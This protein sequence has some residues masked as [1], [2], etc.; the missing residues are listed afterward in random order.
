MHSLSP[1]PW[2]RTWQK[3]PAGPPWVGGH[4][5]EGW[6]EPRY[7][8]VPMQWQ[9]MGGEPTCTGET[10]GRRDG[11]SRI[12][13]TSAALHECKRGTSGSGMSQ[14]TPSSLRSAAVGVETGL[15]W[16]GR[17]RHV[18]F[19][20]CSCGLGEGSGS[21]DMRVWEG[22]E[23]FITWL[24]VFQHGNQGKNYPGHNLSL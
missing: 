13:C 11:A 4:V 20:W 14:E 10:P 16:G 15:A 24:I 2:G 17:V 12:C 22:N 7:L 18:K 1:G 8:F 6:G 3:T 5:R 21:E 9:A 23:G 19:R